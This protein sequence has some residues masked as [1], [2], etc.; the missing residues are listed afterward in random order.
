MEPSF[1]NLTTTE[2]AIAVR[3]ATGETCREI[4]TSRGCSIKTVDTHRA[5]ILK[6][7][8]LTNAVQLALLAVREGEVV[9]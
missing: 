4:A 5:T 2:H 7:L 1:K 3:L 6:K 8:G 9:P